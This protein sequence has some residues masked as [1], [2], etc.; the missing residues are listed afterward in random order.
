MPYYY[1]IEDVDLKK[2]FNGK[3][4][5]AK[6]ITCSLCGLTQQLIHEDTIKATDLIYQSKTAAVST[7]M[8]DYGWGEV[9]ANEF[10]EQ[11]KFLFSPK[12][13]L[14]VG[15]Q[16]GYLLYELYK[17][18][19]KK[20]IGIEPSPQEPIETDGFKANIYN[21]YFDSKRF[22]DEKFDTIISL[23]VLEHLEEPLYFLRSL[24]KVLSKKGQ[25]I[26][27]I[28]NANFQMEQGDPGLFMHEHISH[29]NRVSLNN[30]FNLAGLKI[31]KYKET[32]SDIYLTAQKTTSKISTDQLKNNLPDP[33]INYRE[34]L[35]K[36]LD[37]FK[38]NLNDLEKIGLWGAC[39]TAV[40]LVFMTKINNYVLFDGDEKKQGNEIS[41]IK[42]IINSPSKQNIKNL[43]D[44][45][46]IIPLGFQRMIE[47]SLQNYGIGHFSLFN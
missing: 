43:V 12:D 10:F 26:I 34:A 30:I 11:N 13:V 1:G 15:C 39:P 18:G 8:S 28:P 32:K 27:A 19:A 21:E 4:F 3:Y 29:F 20:L 7:P 6:L 2:I 14:E 46:C 23:F 9:R 5:P 35:N 16:N 40:N 47:S 45:V 37:N 33:L 41:G 24:T 31:L 42:G 17:R 22:K 25:I 38:I 36:V 44:K